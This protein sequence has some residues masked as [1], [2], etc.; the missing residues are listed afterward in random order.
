MNTVDN[1]IELN[2]PGT[3]KSR[4]FDWY[5]VQQDEYTLMGTIVSQMKY[6][7]KH[8]MVELPDLKA[9]QNFV[10]SAKEIV[11]LVL[12]SLSQVFGSDINA[13]IPVPSFNAWSMD[14][15]KGELKVP[16][17]VA[18]ALATRLKIPFLEALRKNKSGT[19][20]NSVLG[21]EH[22]EVI[23]DPPTGKILLLDDLFETGRSAEICTAK[24]VSANPKSQVNFFSLTRNKFG[25]LPK[26]VSLRFKDELVHKANNGNEYIRLSF[27]F[28]S[29]EEQVCIFD[30]HLDFEKIKQ[31]LET[32][33][34]LTLSARVKRKDAE[35]R[36][37]KFVELLRQ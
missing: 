35:S 5:K 18:M 33:P 36:F 12:P 32:D 37:W 13:V 4:A 10:R 27:S 19:S 6:P 21:S 22:F 14:N 30:S 31:K 28:G 17:I 24:L 16:Y 9:K 1:L 23:K 34:T 11:E 26:L 15:K 2:V 8:S 20:K 25:G 29:K 7:K 3:E